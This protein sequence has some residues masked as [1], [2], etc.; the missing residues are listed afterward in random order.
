MGELS[1]QQN[2]NRLSSSNRGKWQVLKTTLSGTTVHRVLVE[3]CLN[4]AEHGALETPGRAVALALCVQWASGATWWTSAFL[5]KIVL[6]FLKRQ[7]T[8]IEGFFLM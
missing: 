1:H 6:F 8:Q 7:R 4:R 5:L 3:A 2:I